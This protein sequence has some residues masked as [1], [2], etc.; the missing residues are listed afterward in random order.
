M[1]HSCRDK[2]HCWHLFDGSLY[3]RHSGHPQDAKADVL[4]CWCTEVRTAPLYAP[5]TAAGT[6]NPG[7]KHGANV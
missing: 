6:I 4:C 3:S 2:G 1:T 5:N 7:Q